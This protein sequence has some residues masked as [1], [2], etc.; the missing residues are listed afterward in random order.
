M[1]ETILNLSQTDQEQ[2]TQWQKTAKSDGGEA[3]ILI[4]LFGLGIFSN[5]LEN[6]NSRDR[7]NCISQTC[8]KCCGIIGIV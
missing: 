4:Q 1:G 2:Q 3:E 7:R 6:Y 5:I 8:L